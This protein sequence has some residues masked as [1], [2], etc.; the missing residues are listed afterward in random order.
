MSGDAL[1]GLIFM[2][3]FVLALVGTPFIA[4]IKLAGKRDHDSHAH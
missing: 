3:L 1:I 4:A 2:A